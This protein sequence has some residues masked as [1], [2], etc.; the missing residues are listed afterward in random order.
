M[1]RRLALAYVAYRLG[2]ALG[3]SRAAAAWYWVLGR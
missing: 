1:K 2:R 3:E